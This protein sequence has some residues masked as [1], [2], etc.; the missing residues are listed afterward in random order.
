MA[1]AIQDR[2]NEFQSN[3]NLQAITKEEI[4]GPWNQLPSSHH[5]IEDIIELNG[6]LVHCEMDTQ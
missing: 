5:R 3:E 6:V 4:F 1:N 2:D